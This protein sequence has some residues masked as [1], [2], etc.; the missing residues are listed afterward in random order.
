VHCVKANT[1]WSID[2]CPMLCQ[3]HLKHAQDPNS[4]PLPEESS[5]TQNAASL[6]SNIGNAPSILHAVIHF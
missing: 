5:W 1:L 2:F 4:D 6:D 3:C